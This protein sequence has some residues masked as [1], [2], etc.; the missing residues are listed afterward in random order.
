MAGEAYWA[1]LLD[2]VVRMIYKAAWS[3]LEYFQREA[4]YAR[5]GSHGRRAD[6]REAWQWREAGLAVAHWL[7]HSSRD[8]DMQLHV[9]SQIAHVCRTVVDGKWQAPDSLGYLEHVVAVGSIVATHFEEAL[10]RRFG[11]RW[12]AREDGRG[13]EIEGIPGELLRVSARA[14]PIST[15]ARRSW[16][17]RSRCGTGA[18]RR[19]ARR[20]SCRRRRTC[21]PARVRKRRD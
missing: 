21:S 10:T 9:H 11:V 3:G 7:Q 13:F 19:G 1:G 4:G 6:S 2:E 15:L 17:R 16:R 8:G 5:T 20:A 14:A 18:S 12:A